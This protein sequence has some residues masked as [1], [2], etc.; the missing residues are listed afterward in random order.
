LQV[1]LFRYGNPPGEALL[2]DMVIDT[3]RFRMDAFSADSGGY[4]KAT[5]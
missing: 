5:V 3:P 1:P 4:S 2:I